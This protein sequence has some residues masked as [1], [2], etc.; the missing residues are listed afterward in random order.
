MKD[1][2][3]YPSADQKRWGFT[4]DRWEDGTYVFLEKGTIWFSMMIAAKQRAGYLT[5]LFNAVKADG[6]K[7][8]VPTPFPKMEAWLKKNGFKQTY[9][10]SEDFCESVEVW[11]EAEPNQEVK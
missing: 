6:F 4:P 3:I 1:G 7:V 10:Y 2:A 11:V 8:K 9:E 5:H